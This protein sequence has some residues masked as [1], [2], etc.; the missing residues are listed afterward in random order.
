MLIHPIRS[1]YYNPKSVM[2]SDVVTP[3]YDAISKEMEAVY[4]NRSPYNF[5]HLILPNPGDPD[6]NVA[7]ERLNQW[8]R[9][10]VLI[11]DAGRHFFLY[12]Q[13][14]TIDSRHHTRDTLMC[15]V[16][17]HEFGDRIIRP[18]ENTYQKYRNDRLMLLKKSKHQLSHIFGMVKDPAGE[19][20]VLYEKYSFKAPFLI[21]RTDDGIEHALW[22]ID[23]SQAQ[24]TLDK[25]FT[26]R[27]IYIVDGHHRYS[28]AIEYS[29]EI[30][31][32]GSDSHP[33]GQ[34]LFCIANVYDPALVVFPT[35]RLIK[36]ALDPGVVEMAL[37]PFAQ[38]PLTPEEL[39]TF[40][41]SKPTQPEFA[42][43]FRGRLMRITNQS[44]A[45]RT[46]SWGESVSRLAVAWSD[47]EL[48][49]SLDV[50][51]SNRSERIF[52]ERDITNA[53]KSRDDYGLCIFHAP[54][55]VE[56]V[57]DVAD[58]GRF[59]PQKSTYF[60]PKLGAGLVVRNV[61]GN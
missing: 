19:L 13:S 57:C 58:E 25:F 49:T 28:S 52:Y 2:V 56:S 10:N 18:H 15:A 3:P 12:R 4:R 46:Q 26:D 61:S 41:K 33:A 40:V 11:E 8:K 35:H 9:L 22:K 45:E 53:W 43:Y 38:F 6:Y 51:D 32:F 39:Q 30:G 23:A 31:A 14:F 20:N 55:P 27:P 1:I 54:T 36:G 21:A 17:L 16:K 7:T 42:V 50:N 24:S 44:G 48:L 59:M 5:T 34:M 29:K 47:W 60:Y 37:K